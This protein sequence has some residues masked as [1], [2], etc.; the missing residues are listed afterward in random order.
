MLSFPAG[1]TSDDAPDE[2]QLRILGN[3]IVSA[4]LSV[5]GV[6]Y[7]NQKSIGLY[8]TTGSADDWC[9]SDDANE[10]NGDYRSAAYT[11]ELRDTGFYGFI[12]PPQQIIPTG[13]EIAAAVLVF[14]EALN[15]E[16]LKKK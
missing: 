11:I 2:E 3:E 9:Y 12:L 5:H 1:W 4:I 16:P 13:E 10:N 7:T 6:R 8:P 15:K 14:A